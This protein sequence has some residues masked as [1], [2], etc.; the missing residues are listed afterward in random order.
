MATSLFIST[1]ENALTRCV[2]AEGVPWAE[3]SHRVS[4]K[5]GNSALLNVWLTICKSGCTS[6]T[7]EE[8]SGQ[9]FTSCTNESIQL[10]CALVLNNLQTII[11]EMAKH[12]PLMHG[13]A[14]ALLNTL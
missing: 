4:A 1:R 5:C 13:S 7:T 12:L 2:L 14:N 8:R 11:D 9:T 3:I 10:V 6:V